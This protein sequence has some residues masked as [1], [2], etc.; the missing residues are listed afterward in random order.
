LER[1]PQVQ[2]WATRAQELAL[3][4]DGKCP[5]D[6]YYGGPYECSTLEQRE[7]YYWACDEA[8]AVYHGS[9]VLGEPCEL[10]GRHMSTCAEHLVCGADEV[11]HAPCDAPEF[12]LAGQRCGAAL[13]LDCVAGLACAASGRC[14]DAAVIGSACDPELPCDADAWCGASGVCEARLADGQPCESH[15]QCLAR[16]CEAG[17]CVAPTLPYCVNPVL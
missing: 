2:A 17:S 16:L 6:L 14:V 12:A 3:H 15:E 1:E 9:A 4:Y 13:G 11:C 10:V 7:R 8:C 5:I